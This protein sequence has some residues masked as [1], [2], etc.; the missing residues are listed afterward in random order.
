MSGLKRA[1]GGERGGD[2]LIDLPGRLHLFYLIARCNVSPRFSARFRVVCISQPD[3]RNA[4][5]NHLKPLL[6]QAM[7]NFF[8]P[9]ID[10]P[11]PPPPPKRTI[12]GRSTEKKTVWQPSTFWLWTFLVLLCVLLLALHS[13]IFSLPWYTKRARTPPKWNA[14]EL[15]TFWIAPQICVSCEIKKLNKHKLSGNE[16]VFISSFLLG[17]FGALEALGGVREREGSGKINRWLH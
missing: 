14:R 16:F 1:R 17:S 2:G 15:K 12:F 3:I 11:S 4:R 5:V 10:T 7:K 13:S 9:S 6:A 8:R